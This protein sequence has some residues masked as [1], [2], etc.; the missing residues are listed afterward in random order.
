M[1]RSKHIDFSKIRYSTEKFSHRVEIPHDL[2]YQNRE[3]IGD[4][5]E[6]NNRAEYT[7]VMI[8]SIPA[9][10]QKNAGSARRCFMFVDPDDCFDFKIAWG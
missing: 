7:S 9:Y 5:L 2:Y 6:I 8:S 1:T 10:Y 4:W 3:R